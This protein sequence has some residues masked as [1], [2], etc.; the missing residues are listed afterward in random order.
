MIVSFAHTTAALLCG[1]K[2]ATRRAWSPSHAARFRPGDLVDAWDRS[3]RTRLGHKVATIR[4]SRAPYLQPTHLTTPEDFHR[5]GFAWIRD[6]GTPAARELVSRIWREWH[7]QP[8]EMYV[9]EFELVSTI[10]QGCT[11]T[12]PHA[13]GVTPFPWGVDYRCCAHCALGPHGCRCAF[14]QPGVAESAHALS[15][16][17]IRELE[18]ALDR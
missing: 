14:G 5:E 8:S 11:A 9:V 7:E 2:T 13:L 10:C 4:I 15:D 18:E 17:Q 12:V 6:Y 3:P 1:S 16:E